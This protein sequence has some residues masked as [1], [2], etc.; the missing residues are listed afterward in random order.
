MSWTIWKLNIIIQGEKRWDRLS[1][2]RREITRELWK[3]TSLLCQHNKFVTTVAGQIV[4][5]FFTVKQQHQLCNLKDFSN[6]NPSI[7]I[8]VQFIL[9]LTSVECKRYNSE[10][11]KGPII[12]AQTEHKLND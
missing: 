3:I 7:F 12:W 1:T 5:I 9:V 6:N 11:I 4:L 2:L 10:N 8:Y